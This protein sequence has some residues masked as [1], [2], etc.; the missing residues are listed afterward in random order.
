MITVRTGFS[1]DLIRINTMGAKTNRI[2]A[3]QT[4]PLAA[5]GDLYS[6]ISIPHLYHGEIDRRQRPHHDHRGRGDLLKIQIAEVIIQ[7]ILDE[8]DRLRRIQTVEKIA[9]PKQPEKADQVKYKKK[10]DMGQELER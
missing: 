4:A 6:F 2:S 5:A 8:I 7:I 9:L 10:F 1:S 3:P